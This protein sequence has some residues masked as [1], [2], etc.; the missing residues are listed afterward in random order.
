MQIKWSSICIQ[1]LLF[2]NNQNNVYSHP[3]PVSLV[4][5]ELRAAQALKR[6]QKRVGYFTRKHQHIIS[7]RPVFFDF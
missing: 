7:G 4:I 1:L 2:H 3:F 6:E 5:V